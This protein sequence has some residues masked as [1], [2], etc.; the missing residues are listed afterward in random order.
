MTEQIELTASI[1][2]DDVVVPFRTEAS[3]IMGRLVRL[4]PT[5]Q[6]ILSRHDFP[7]PVAEVMGEALALTA[8]LGAGLKFEGKLILQTRTD[9]PLGFLVTNY[10]TPGHLRGYASYD[11]DGIAQTRNGSP[12]MAHGT[13]IGEGHLA[14]TIDQGRDMD[15]YQG[16][17]PLSGS[18]LSEAAQLYFRQSEQLPT[19]I[20]LAVARVAS[21]ADDQT[22]ARGWTWRAGGILV[23]HL[24]AQGG[25][26]P[27][28]NAP[29]DFLLGDDDE[30]WQRVNMLAATVEDHELVDP[31]LTPERLLFRL[32]NE[33]GVRVFNDHHLS[34]YCQC[35]HDRVASLLKTFASDELDEMRNANGDVSVVCEFCGSEYVVQPP[36]QDNGG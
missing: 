12:G 3:G 1:A 34:D 22:G 28:E 23:Q 36:D 25:H 32:F 26:P 18:T 15:R 33:E 24:A 29:Q 7:V 21:E 19:F 11:A 5:A 31:S 17:V 8:I 16:I 35:S 6:N 20:R 27:P 9:G 4:G 14:L 10:Q 2:R 30:N 13:L